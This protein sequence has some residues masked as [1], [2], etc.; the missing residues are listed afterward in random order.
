MNKVFPI[1]HFGGWSR[2]WSWQDENSS[3]NLQSVESDG[4]E[5]AS[6]RF[7][8]SIF[9]PSPEATKKI[10]QHEITLN[11][12]SEFWRHETFK[13]KTIKISQFLADLIYHSHFEIQQWILMLKSSFKTCE[14]LD[15]EME[16]FD[17][18]FYIF[19]MRLGSSNGRGDSQSRSSKCFQSLTHSMC[20]LP[21]INIT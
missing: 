13:W 10:Y 18:H 15:S 4:F 21:I 12:N 8:W 6:N 17:C 11:L 5:L 3:R 7:H 20:G 2:W 1:D 16:I 14:S 9:W 19:S